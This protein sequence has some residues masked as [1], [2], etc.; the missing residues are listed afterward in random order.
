M[1][2]SKPDHRPEIPAAS[3]NSGSEL[4]VEIFRKI[5]LMLQNTADSEITCGQ[6]TD[7]I[8]EYVEL[9]LQGENPAELMP[10]FKLHLDLC[11]GCHE[12]FDALM[13]IMNR[14]MEQ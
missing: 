11:G 8:D 9:G 12:E 1:P 14:T 3:L 13:R 7:L 5:A 2:E 4:S 6:F 10:L